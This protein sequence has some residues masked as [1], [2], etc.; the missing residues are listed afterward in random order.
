MNRYLVLGNGFDI[1]HNL[2]TSY[3]DFLYVCAEFIELPHNIQ[4]NNINIKKVKKTF[5]NKYKDDIEFKKRIKNNLWLNFFYNKLEKIGNNWIDFER[6]IKIQ[7][8]KII[9]RTTG[10]YIYDSSDSILNTH[11]ELNDLKA[12]L[13]ELIFILNRYL[14]IVNRIKITECY[15]DVINFMPTHIINFNYTN[16]FSRVYKHIDIDYIH[17]SINRNDLNTIVL[18]FEGMNDE[19]NDIEFGDFLKYIQMVQND[20]IIDCYAEMQKTND[21]ESTFFGHSLDET[22]KDIIMK[23]VDCSLRVNILYKDNDMKNSIIKNLIKIYG[24]NEFMRL[25]LSKD[26]KIYFF[27]QCEPQLGAKKEIELI[28][29]IFEEK[30]EQFSDKFI[31]NDTIIQLIDK[32]KINIIPIEN[33]FNSLR[34]QLTEANKYL[35]LLKYLIDYLEKSDNMS[36][37]TQKEKK[38]LIKKINDFVVRYEK[39][40]FNKVA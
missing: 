20:I 12:G 17:G 15:S 30:T 29:E 19:K 22:D 2:P 21:N 28:Y 36:Y 27:K 38:A 33:L 32:Y 40:H 26:K 9:E 7:C 39:N 8:E 4:V 23:I 14:V 24:R 18:G 10:N 35:N 34:K 5:L 16:T 11:V 13:K 25:T 6:E 1:A 37:R 3:K 31:S